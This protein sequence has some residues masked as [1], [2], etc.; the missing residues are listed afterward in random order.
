MDYTIVRVYGWE[1]NPYILPTFLTLRT[2]ALEIL[3]KRF[4]YDYIHFSKQ[5]Q[6]ASFK[7]PTTIGPFTVKNRST[8]QLIKD[9]LTCFR[10][11]GYVSCQYDLVRVIHEKRKK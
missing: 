2:F 6:A 10:F 9:M 5:N 11:E 8:T 7:L 4:D 3:R 1:I